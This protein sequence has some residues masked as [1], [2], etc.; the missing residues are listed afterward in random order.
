MSLEVMKQA[1][2]ALEQVKPLYTKQH[3]ISALRQAIAQAEK[4]QWVWLTDEEIKAIAN[5]SDDE[6]IPMT[7]RMWVF[8]ANL[9][10]AIKEKNT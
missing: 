8:V 1:L 5:P 3:A 6:Q 4:R 2:E 9:M 7:G 10:E